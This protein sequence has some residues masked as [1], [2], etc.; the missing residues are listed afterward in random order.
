MFII[1]TLEYAIL[2]NEISKAS[3]KLTTK[4]HKQYKRFWFWIRKF[5]FSIPLQNIINFLENPNF[6]AEF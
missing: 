6:K 5:Y 1:A 2:T 3:F 4:Q